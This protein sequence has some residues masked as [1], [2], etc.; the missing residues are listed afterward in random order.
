MR[1]WALT[2]AKDPRQYQHVVHWTVLVLVMILVVGPAGYIF[3]GSF[4][5]DGVEPSVGYSLEAWR[6]AF[7][8][9]AILSS[10]WSTFK[11]TVARQAI[12]IPLAILLAWILARTDVPGTRWLE[13]LFWMGYFLPALPVTMGW[14]LLLDPDFG[15]LNQ[16]LAALP[17]IEKGPFNIYSFW[18]IVWAHLGTATI[19][20]EVML[21]T[22]AFRNLDATL[23][24]ASM[25]AGAGKLSTL[26]RI[27]VP[28]MTPVVVAVTLLAVVHS[29]QAF[30]LELILGFP[31]KFYVFSTK[32]YSL[33]GHDPPLFSAATALSSVILLIM[34]PLIVAQRWTS[35]RRS[36]TTV[37]G[38]YRV[39]KVQLGKWRLAVFFLVL[40]VAL[41]VTAV[42]FTFLVLG[43]LMLRFGYFN[44]PKPWTIM[45]WGRVLDDP[46]FLNSLTNTLIL[47]LGTAIAAVVLFTAIS[48]IVIRTRFVGRAALDFASWV[49]S[50]LPGVILG[51]GLLSIS[52]GTPLLRPLYGSMLLLI[53]A[54]VV[55]SMTIGVQI[56][57]SNFDQLGYELEEAAQVCGG[58]GWNAIRDILLPII[59]PALLLVGAVS[60]IS[61]A[62]N[63]STVALLASSDTRPLSL[64]QLDYLF[65]YRYESAAVVGVIVVV[66][67]L[68]V[69]LIARVL[70]LRVG[71]PD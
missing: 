38:R 60:F 44:L 21:F 71:L 13:F 67:T 32:I 33:I 53:V 23:E 19:A 43:T 59:S 57:K 41:T 22:P 1:D 4:R 24:E 65:E 49:P 6:L 52:L 16:W 40:G 54:T 64:L 62:R 8:D 61:A 3:L 29:L 14:I 27:V 10:I 39:G 37:G 70:G 15:L 30:E 25:V 47:A 18:G 51:V 7:S 68:G 17:F 5:G 36:Y 20:V 2:L 34:L 55:S 26:A 56:L 42:P 9:P 28:V 58:S 48:Y 12:A 69:A 11:I 46:V 63:V 50:S 31:I 35:E 45:H 66:I